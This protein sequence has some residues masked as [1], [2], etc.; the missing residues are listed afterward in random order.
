MKAIVQDRYGSPDVLRLAEV[1]T[2]VPK[3]YEV[4]I[5]VFARPVSYGDLIARN[6]RNVSPGQFNMP[7]PLWLISRI[8]FGLKKPRI[9]VLGAELAGKVEL[10]GPKVTRF[11]VGD[12]VYAYPGIKFGANAE[13]VCMHE[14][15]M[16]AHK[17]A[18]MSNEE[19][20]AVPYGA[21]TAL[22]LLRK[23]NIQSGQ[24]V[25]VVGASGTIGSF[26]VQLAKYYGAEVTGVCSTKRLDFVRQLGADHVVDYTQEDF[27]QNG[28]T[29]DVIVDILGRSSWARCKKSL[30]ENGRYLLASFKTTQWMQ[31]F[32]TSIIGKKKVL[33]VMS[34]YKK[35]D[36]NVIRQ[37]IEAGAVRTIID[38]SFPLEQTA[39]A[40]RYIEAGNKKGSVVITSL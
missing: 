34:S 19:A 25:I 21:M 8:V 30:K 11:Q 36:L 7:M 17:P 28:E 10:V 5:Q 16:I 12:A 23:V 37:W 38:K 9:S 35:E 20:A 22:C 1:E 2:P 18:N 6:F 3:E 29:Y 26:V 4:R 40:H 24:K 31:M 14:N 15:D 32:L 39:D 13:Y 33:C 27:T